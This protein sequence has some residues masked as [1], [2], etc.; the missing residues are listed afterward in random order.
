ML[1]IYNDKQKQPDIFEA[2]LPK[3]LFELDE[4]LKGIDI[5]LASE[6]FIKPFLEEYPEDMGRPTLPVESYLRMMYLK[7]RYELGYESLVRAVSDSIRWRTFCKFKLGDAVPDP[8]T[9]GKTTQRLGEE[10]LR[11]QYGLLLTR[12]R[13]QK[14]LR[15]PRPA[16]ASLERLAEPKARG[17]AGQGSLDTEKGGGFL[18]E[19]FSTLRKTMKRV[20]MAGSQAVHQIKGRTRDTEAVERGIRGPGSEDGREDS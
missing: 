17:K 3:E 1:R 18:S 11:E 9:L 2:S 15:R 10:A 8:T 7:Y 4:E 13:E 5:L 6:D 20:Q 19:G 14:V 12:A 16:A